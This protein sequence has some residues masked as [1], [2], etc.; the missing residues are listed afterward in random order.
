MRVGRCFESGAQHGV[1]LESLERM[2]LWQAKTPGSLT[3]IEYNTETS[4][5]SWSWMAVYG[6]VIFMEIQF[7]SVEWT[8]SIRRPET[9][10]H[11][12]GRLEVHSNG[13]VIG[14]EEPMEMVVLD[15]QENAI[16]DCRCV[17]VGK[18][19]TPK[20]AG[21]VAH[22]VLLIRQASTIGSHDDFSRV[23]VATLFARHISPETKTVFL[24]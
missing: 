18:G 9:T 6:P 20:V 8:K 7:G 23:G 12:D 24:V 13:L 2:L 4:V 19:K 10:E 22:Y 17:V 5:P 14:N 11:W 3:K 15:G 21:G 1:L 16:R